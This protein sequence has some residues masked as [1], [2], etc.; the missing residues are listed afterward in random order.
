MLDAYF[1]ME[2]ERSAAGL[3]PLASDAT[4]G[5]GGL[6]GPRDGGHGQGG[7]APRPPRGPRRSRRRPGGQ[8]QGR[9]AGGRGQGE[10]DLAGCRPR[11]RRPHPRHDARRLQRRAPRR[12]PLGQGHRRRR[13][14]GP[15][16]DRPCLRPLRH[17]SSGCRRRT[18]TPSPSSDPG[19]RGSGSCR[20]PPSPKRS[21][22][23]S[24]RSTAR[25]TR[26]ISRRPA[27][28]RPG[29]TS[30]STPSRWARSA[31]PAATTS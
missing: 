14:R 13:G 24:S 16:E 4:G 15:E 11:G 21:S 7:N 28:P 30:P 17:R 9:V 31:S 12:G 2:K 10:R 1:A 19:R 18:P 8:G 5:R 25:S 26:T 23:R 20:A 29:R 3:P 22:S 6:S 27:T